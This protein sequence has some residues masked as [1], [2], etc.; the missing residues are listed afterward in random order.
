[1]HE[2]NP[3]SYHADSIAMTAGQ[4]LS[5]RV[6]TKFDFYDLLPHDWSIVA[7]ADQTAVTIAHKDGIQSSVFSAPPTLGAYNP[8]TAATA[9]L[10][11]TTLILTILI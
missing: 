7:L 10:A 6:F 1:M 2:V 9:I 5:V 8:L 3:G 11:A 4:E